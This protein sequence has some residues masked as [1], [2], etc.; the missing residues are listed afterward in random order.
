MENTTETTD[1]QDDEEDLALEDPAM[2]S[3]LATRMVRE[4]L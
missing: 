4:A 1:H 3:R 2:A